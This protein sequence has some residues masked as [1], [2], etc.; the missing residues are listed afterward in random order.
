MGDTV[1][2]HC[3]ASRRKTYKA[4][5]VSSTCVFLCFSLELSW[6]CC[7]LCYVW[8]SINLYCLLE[9][10][11]CNGSG[12]SNHFLFYR[13]PF[14]APNRSGFTMSGKMC[15][16]HFEGKR[17]STAAVIPHHHAGDNNDPSVGYS[18]VQFCCSAFSSIC[19]NSSF[20]HSQITLLYSLCVMVL[21]RRPNRALSLPTVSRMYYI[22]YSI[23]Y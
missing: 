9:T 3:L 19:W 7:L 22:N 21:M 23:Q 20:T 5:L 4:V 6:V 8:F 18:L 10:P 2:P 13:S 16:Q 12:L 15:T 14:Q 11:L 17:V 1:P